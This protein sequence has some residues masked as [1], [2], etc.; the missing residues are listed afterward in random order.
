MD[1]DKK[2]EDITTDDWLMFNDRAYNEGEGNYADGFLIGMY[3]GD[4]SI[5]DRTNCDS[6]EV[7]LSLN[8]EKYLNAY[9]I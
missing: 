4:G 9:H 7:T 5:Y 2:A 8:E 6:V 1:G 3:L